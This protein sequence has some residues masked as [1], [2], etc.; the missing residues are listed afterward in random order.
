L[1]PPRYNAQSELT[2]E[3]KKGANKVSYRLKST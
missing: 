2:A 1:I 3:V